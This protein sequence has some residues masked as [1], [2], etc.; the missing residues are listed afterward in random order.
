MRELLGALPP[1]VYNYVRGCELANEIWDTLKVKYQGSEKTK[2]SFLKQCVLELG[3]FKQKDDTNNR[4]VLRSSNQ[5]IFKSSRYGVIHS[6]IEYNLAF[7]MGL[8]K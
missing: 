2:K 3:E 6:T 5:L 1:V 7:L 8:R 4:N